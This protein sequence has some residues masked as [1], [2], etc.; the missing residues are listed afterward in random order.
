MGRPVIANI[1]PPSRMGAIMA[2]SGNGWSSGS[3]GTSGTE[4]VRP[5]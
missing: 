2:S 1:A 3:R 5:V 4:N